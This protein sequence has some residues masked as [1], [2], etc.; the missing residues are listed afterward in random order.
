MQSLPERVVLLCEVP[1]G[2][3][4]HTV[5][6]PVDSSIMRIDSEFLSSNITPTS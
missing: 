2:E 3:N 1:E 4:I 5:F 6:A